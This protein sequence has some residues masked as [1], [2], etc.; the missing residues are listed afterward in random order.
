M[1]STHC[2]LFFFFLF[3]FPP[4]S[5]SIPQNNLCV[6]FTVQECDSGL[7]NKYCQDLQLAYFESVRIPAIGL[8]RH[9]TANVAKLDWK[10]TLATEKKKKS[11]YARERGKEITSSS[12]GSMMPVSECKQVSPDSNPIIICLYA[13]SVELNLVLTAT[14]LIQSKYL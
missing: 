1:L 2:H 12:Q 5:F 10:Q 13:L 7:S 8:T 9:H 4:V 6:T 3:P 11:T 14:L